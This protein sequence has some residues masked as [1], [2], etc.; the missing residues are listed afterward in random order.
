M[1]T[2]LKRLIRRQSP[3]TATVAEFDDKLSPFSAIGGDYSR[4]CRRGL[5]RAMEIYKIQKLYNIDNLIY[6]HLNIQMSVHPQ[7][8]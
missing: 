5:S 4:Q 2:G 7:H 3:K 8:H 1:W 6:F